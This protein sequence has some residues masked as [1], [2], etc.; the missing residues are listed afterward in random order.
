MLSYF[1]FFVYIYE[2]KV[3]QLLC[4]NIEEYK[5]PKN[6]IKIYIQYSTLATKKLGIFYR[7]CKIGYIDRSSNQTMLVSMNCFFSG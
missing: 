6:N 1:I 4:C 5:R 3:I 2:H 7:I